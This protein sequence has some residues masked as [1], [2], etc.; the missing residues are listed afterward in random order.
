MIGRGDGL[1]FISIT[2]DPVSGL[3]TVG[4][5]TGTPPSGLVLPADVS[6]T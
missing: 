4:A 6:A 2:I 5:V 1:R 3:T